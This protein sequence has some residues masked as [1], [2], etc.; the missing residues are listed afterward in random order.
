METEEI[1]EK[2]NRLMSKSVDHVLH[3]FSTLHTGK[4]SPSMVENVLIWMMN[5]F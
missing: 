4:A 2:M 5:F 3:E 1:F